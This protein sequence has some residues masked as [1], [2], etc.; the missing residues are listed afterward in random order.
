DALYL[1]QRS[2][3][4]AQRR[5]VTPKERESRVHIGSPFRRRLGV[6][7][8]LERSDR[9]LFAARQGK[10]LADVKGD[11]SS[12]GRCQ[13]ASVC[14]GIPSQQRHGQVGTADSGEG[15]RAARAA[16]TLEL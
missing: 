2:A 6:E 10:G 11:L 1:S 13:T 14:L 4:V 5:R 3:G 12:L 7:R 8:L 9:F 15:A 16:Y